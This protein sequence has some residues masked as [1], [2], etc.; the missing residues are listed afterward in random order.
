MAQKYPA[1][2]FTE[3][4]REILD[5]VT[6]ESVGET[7]KDRL[8]EV[9]TDTEDKTLLAKT[10]AELF[11][12]MFEPEQGSELVDSLS[13]EYYELAPEDKNEKTDDLEAAEAFD[14]NGLEI[15]PKPKQ[16]KESDSS[17]TPE[18]PTEGEE[19]E[20]QRTLSEFL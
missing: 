3:A 14:E 16:K 1:T 13:K 15:E 20:E 11:Y 7:L 17:E 19:T 18:A 8:K 2:Y 4:A 5:D 12:D 6:D 9:F 10:L